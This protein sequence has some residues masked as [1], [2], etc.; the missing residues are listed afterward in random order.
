M[1]QDYDNAYKYAK[2]ALLKYHE[3]EVFEQYIQQYEQGR[4]RKAI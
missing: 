4:F 2:T 3:D 1:A